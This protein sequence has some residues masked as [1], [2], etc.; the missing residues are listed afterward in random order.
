M[1]APAD[2]AD[3]IEPAPGRGPA[4][5]RWLVASLVV[6]ALAFA[7][8]ALGSIRISVDTSGLT[9]PQMGRP[10]PDFR[11]QDLAGRLTSLSDFRGRPVVVNFWASWCIPCRDEAPLLADS[12]ARYGAAGLQILGV[13]FQ[14]DAGSAQAFMER[15]ALRYPGL[16]DPDGRTA[17]DYGVRGIPQT[18]MIDRDG[19]TRRVI[20]GPLQ[21]DTF[22][23][24]IEEIL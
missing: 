22:R 8:L 21:V 19:T 17:I 12:Q 5:P 4:R 7:I 10:A 18:F 24:A 23:A 16:L 13:V 9:G 2:M 6:A 11:L 1:A 14:D 15:F 3:P 20:L